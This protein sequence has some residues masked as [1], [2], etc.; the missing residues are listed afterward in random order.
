MS[1]YGTLT[2]AGT[3]CFERL[4]PATAERVWEY[5]TASDLRR[6]WFAGGDMELNAGGALTLIFRNS[7]LSHH[8]EEV[9][10]RF[11]EYEG[12]ESKGKIVAAEPPRRLVF[13][14][15]EQAGPPTEVEFTLEPRGDDTLLTLIHRRLP[16][17][18][19]AVDV[20]GGWHIHLDML[21]DILAGHTPRPFWS[22]QARYEQEYAERLPA[23]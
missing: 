4:L 23:D 14:W 17:R 16:S 3:V 2:E 19:M 15:F 18:A 1:D 7:E 11:R 10:E 12:M 13:E 8:G 20:A 6:K 21:E 22:T 9:P 5:L